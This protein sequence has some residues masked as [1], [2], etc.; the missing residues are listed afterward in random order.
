M[1][2][3]IQLYIRQVLIGFGLAALFVAGLLALD[4]A[5]LWH[6]VSHSSMG[7]IAVTML[8]FANGIVFAGVQFAITIMRMGDADT[9]PRGGRRQG[10]LV[11]V[12]VPAMA[13][14]PRTSRA[15][16]SLMRR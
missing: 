4:V 2:Q 3:L 8:W 6:L 11:P 1:P 7:W 12:R 14:K 9:P 15:L 5:R 10:A 13:H 16:H